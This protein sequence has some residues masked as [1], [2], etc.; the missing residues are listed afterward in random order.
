MHVHAV[1][2]RTPQVFQRLG[3]AHLL[4]RACGNRASAHLAH[5]PAVFDD[6]RFARKHAPDA[7]DGGLTPGRE[8]K[9]QKLLAA[10]RAKLRRHEAGR[11]QRLRLRRERET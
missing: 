2:E 5:D 1:D 10:P 4:G 11:D 3:L 9:L 6:Q 7:V 8:L